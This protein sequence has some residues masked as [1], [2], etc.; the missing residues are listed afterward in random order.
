MKSSELSEK[1]LLCLSACHSIGQGDLVCVNGLCL[2]VPHKGEPCLL[3][4]WHRIITQ[5]TLNGKQQ[6]FIMWLRSAAPASF[7][8]AVYNRV[9][10]V[11]QQ[12]H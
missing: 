10:H 3:T 4:S 7:K 2:I 1:E 9:P 12:C 6:S 11:P 5:W 8:A